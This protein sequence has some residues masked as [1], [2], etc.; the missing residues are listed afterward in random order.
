M[1][2]PSQ[3]RRSRPITRC[4]ICDS[5]SLA[6]VLFLGYV[7]PVNTMPPLGRAAEEQR[8]FPLELLRCG[9]CGHVQIGLEVDA[10][11]LFP[12][13]YPYLSA[14]TRILR[15]NFA[16][17][18]A[19]AATMLG[20]G[21]DSLCVDIGSNDGTLLSNF[22]RG[23]Q[24]VLGI[25]PSH[26]SDIANA[27]GI[28]T[29][30]TFFNR[31]VAARVRRE[32][33]PASLVTAAN[34][35]AHIAD[36]HAVVDGILDMLAPDGV[37]ASENHYLKGVIETL[38]YDTI[39]HE[40]LRYYH[41]HALDRLFARH[42]MEI[43]HVRPIPTHGGSIRVYAARKGQRPVQPSVAEMR[44]AEAAAGL[45][46]GAALGPFRQKVLQ[47]KL[48]LIALIAPLKRQGAR[49]YGIGAPSRASTLINYVGLDDGMVECVLEISTSKKLDK[50][51]PGTRIP[52]L[53]EKKLFDDQ[54][55]Y[56]LLLSWHIADELIANLRRKGFNGRFIVPLPD[57]HV[58]DA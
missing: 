35:F 42:G 27:A 45:V 39:Y 3:H 26:A 43:F 16:A 10:E 18:Q 55:E 36:P 50:Y 24:R 40:H 11:V 25:E 8:A 58:V 5:A 17:L 30:M 32:K 31:D 49:V 51:I 22:K 56:A 14:S 34:V 53:D 29:W 57:P 6:S 15:D 52:V 33:G 1:S 41:V 20:L 46:D 19:E 4:Q 21:A 13:D 38:Q 48:D 2:Q 54:P 28:E 12:P 9:A 7:P 37:F 44:A 23:G 47:S